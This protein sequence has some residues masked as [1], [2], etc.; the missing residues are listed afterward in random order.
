MLAVNSPAFHRIG[1]VGRLLPF[2]E[3]RLDPAPGIEGGGRLLVR[4]PNIMIGYYR[5]DNPGELEPPPDGWHDT[6]DIV[7]IDDEGFVTIKGRAKRFAK[8]ATKPSSSIT[9]M[10]P[11]S[12]QPSGGGS[13]SPGLSAR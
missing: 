1:T 10:S 9:T 3:P 4:G 12:R 5:A 13:S 2:V 11:V 7:V 8:I 6:G